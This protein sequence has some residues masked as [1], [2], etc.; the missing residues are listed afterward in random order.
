MCVYICACIDE[1][2]CICLIFAGKVVDFLGVRPFTA[3]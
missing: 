1:I 3:A 2:K